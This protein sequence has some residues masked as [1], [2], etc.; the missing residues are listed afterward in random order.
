[1]DNEGLPKAA[2]KELLE[3]LRRVAEELRRLDHQLDIQMIKGDVERSL[4]T[5]KALEIGRKHFYLLSQ[6]HKK[7]W[8]KRHSSSE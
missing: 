4:R 7:L 6:Q 5:K 2:E 1:M 8:R 3:Q